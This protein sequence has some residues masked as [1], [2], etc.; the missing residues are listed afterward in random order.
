M[1][2]QTRYLKPFRG[3]SNRATIQGRLYSLGEHPGVI[4]TAIDQSDP[5]LGELFS[6][7]EDLE[8][9]RAIL[10]TL[11]AYEDFRPADPASSLFLR[12][13]V[14]ATL[15]DSPRGR[16]RDSLLG[17]HLQPCSLKSGSEMARGRPQCPSRIFW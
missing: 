17:L 16:N 8:A 10:A 2:A 4:L 15:L 3:G 5:V 12:Q 11:D 1:Q 7:S 14:L 13:R 9:A 6:F